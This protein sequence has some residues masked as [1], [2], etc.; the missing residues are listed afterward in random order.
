MKP[1]RDN[2]EIWEWRGCLDEGAANVKLE[3]FVL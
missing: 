2:K 3:R 1:H